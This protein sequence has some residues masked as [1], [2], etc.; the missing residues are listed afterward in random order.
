MRARVVGLLLASALMTTRADAQ[1]IVTGPPVL[2]TGCVLGDV[3]ACTSFWFAYLG[4]DVY[5]FWQ[6]NAPTAI[7]TD[8]QV[9]WYI[10]ED[11]WFQSA[12]GTCSGA[13]RYYNFAQGDCAITQR[14]QITFSAQVARIDFPD[15][16]RDQIVFSPAAAVAPE[17]ATLALVATGLAGLG[18]MRRRRTRGKRSARST[19]CG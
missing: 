5:D 3:T 9:W 19:P 2:Y 11:W 10:L 7:L 13:T 14:Y 8:S 15:Q 18:A 4:P 6:F 1:E 16:W 17:P 12:D